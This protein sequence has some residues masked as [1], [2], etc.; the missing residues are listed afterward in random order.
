MT[1]GYGVIG[2]SVGVV[3]RNVRVD[4]RRYNSDG[5]SVTGDG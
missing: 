2:K 3:T 5:W 1:L 4:A